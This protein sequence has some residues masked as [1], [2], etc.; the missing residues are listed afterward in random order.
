[1]NSSQISILRGN[2]WVG[3][4]PWKPQFQIK[5]NRGEKKT[6][7][8]LKDNKTKLTTAGEKK[9]T[10]KPRGRILGNGNKNGFK[11]KP[12]WENTS[13]KRFLFKAQWDKSLNKEGEL[14]KGNG[15]LTICSRGKSM[16]LF[17]TI[18]PVPE[19][20]SEVGKSFSCSF[21]FPASCFDWFS[22]HLA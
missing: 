14:H 22:S 9:Q 17:R 5:C 7:F 1:M 19:S 21:S 6:T 13:P 4:W 2:C 11:F 20:C 8:L 3:C 16:S 15:P 10:K 18:P 12:E